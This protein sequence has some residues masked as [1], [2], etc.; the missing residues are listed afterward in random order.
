[1]VDKFRTQ[2]LTKSY[3]KEVQLIES[4]SL[5]SLTKAGCRAYSYFSNLQMGMRCSLSGHRI[6]RSSFELVVISY[7]S[8]YSR[9]RRGAPPPPANSSSRNFQKRT[10]W[11]KALLL[12]GRI[13]NTPAGTHSRSC[14]LARPRK[15]A[16]RLQHCQ[17]HYGQFAVFWN[18]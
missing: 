17:L 13:G 2:V 12:S 14:S 11:G 8:R 16:H 5:N 18:F 1:M 10:R 6:W 15:W 3:H 9:W 7:L 4:A